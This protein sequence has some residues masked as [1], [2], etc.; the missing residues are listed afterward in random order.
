LKWLALREA[1]LGRRHDSCVAAEKAQQA[2]EKDPMQA[3][4]PAFWIALSELYQQAELRP[5][6]EA[7]VRKA[8]RLAPDRLGI[9]L[10]LIRWL[11]E[12]GQWKAALEQAQDSRQQFLNRPDVQALVDDI[13]VMKS[14][15]TRAKE[16]SRD[17]IGERGQRL[18]REPKRAP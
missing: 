6:A 12:D 15:P 3:K 16:V 13:L 1:D 14:P 2:V 11:M 9:H 10:L 18:T 5:Q 4:N 7:C 17:S 8:V